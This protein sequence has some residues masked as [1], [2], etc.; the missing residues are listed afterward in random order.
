MLSVNNLTFSYPKSKGPTLSDFSL[1]LREEGIYGLLGSN[2]A[3][4]TTL[5][6]L[7][8]G[9]LT[10]S[11]GNVTLD[12][13]E[14]RRR[15]PSTM[16]EI[17]IV[18]EEVNFPSLSLRKFI[19]VTAPLYP[20][21]SM[22][23]MKAHLATFGLDEDI[24]LGRLSMGQKKKAMLAFAMACNTKVLLMD[25][26]T[27]GLDIPGKSAFRKFISGA[28]TDG[29][30]III[31]THQVRDVGQ[32]LDHLLI[33]NNHQVLLDQSVA[34]VQSKLLF[35]ETSDPSVMEK[36]IYSQKS[37]AGISAIVPNDGESE[38]EI[39]LEM[40]FEYAITDPEGLNSIFNK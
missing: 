29:R 26:P 28:M 4:K 38:T 25:E 15:L 12:G 34:A 19:A 18:P 22:E 27:N 31:S 30:V 8:C 6:F 39:N 5:L 40:L 13:I 16:S 23:E 11:K 35:A 33:I 32:I 17:F 37:I 1:Q 2:G 9:L 21:F 20:R 36:A 14:T 10:P 7:M 3:G 24:H